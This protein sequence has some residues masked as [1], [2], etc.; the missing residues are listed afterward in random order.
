MIVA[1]SLTKRYGRVEALLQLDFE[2]RQGEVVALLGTNGAGKTTTI[3]LILGLARPTAGRVEVNGHVAGDMSLRNRIG[4]CPEE[5]RLHEF[6]TVEEILHFYAEL[7]GLPRRR[8]F[9]EIDR[10]SRLCGIG[11]IRNRKAGRISKG[12]AQRVSLAQAL[13]GDPPILLLDEPTSGLDPIGRISVRDLIEQLHFEGKTILINS[14]M[15]SEVERTCDRAIILRQ[16]RKVWEGQ[17][18]ALASHDEALQVR[19]KGLSELARKAL[20]NLGFTI[21]ANQEGWTVSPCPPS[22]VPEVTNALTAAGARIEALGPAQDALEGLFLELNP[23]SV[24]DQ[25]ARVV[26]EAFESMS[27]ELNGGKRHVAHHPLVN[28]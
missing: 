24:E 7:G 20:V 4:Y 26:H 13:L 3:K 15:L 10:V 25:A 11:D 17:L 28:S 12:Q 16:G 5:P 18:V 14:H 22:R 23:P 6:L 9:A 27:V 1:H 19:A 8:R 2:I 21:H